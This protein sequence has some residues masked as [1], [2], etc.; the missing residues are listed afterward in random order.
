[1]VQPD[2]ALRA[3]DLA[4]LHQLHTACL[5]EHRQEV[6]GRLLVEVDLAVD[7]RRHGGLRIGDPHQFDAIDAGNLGAGEGGRRLGARHIVLV[8]EIDRL[9]ARNPLILGKHVGTGSHGFLH[10]LLRIGERILLAH[11][12]G[13]RALALAQRLQHHAVGFAQDHGEGLVVDRLHLGDEAH[14]TLADAILGAPALQRGDHVLGRDRRSV[15]ELEPIA[16]GEGIGEPV[17]ADLVLAHHLGLRLLVAVVAEQRVVDQCAMDVGD[18]L[19]GPHWIDDAH[20][21]MHHRLEY[22]FLRLHVGGGKRHGQRKRAG[23]NTP[24]HTKVSLTPLSEYAKPPSSLSSATHGVEI[25]RSA[26]AALH[27]DRAARSG[28]RPSGK[29]PY[30]D[31]VE[32][33]RSIRHRSPSWRS[34]RRPP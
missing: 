34:G 17:R 5:F 1:M 11:D 29:G 22:L 28:A 4:G 10:L 8:L 6:V 18:R 23:E 12:G 2:H 25:R 20:I 14:Q 3:V 15:V 9:A 32:A 31:R 21:G 24:E 19:G 13:D 33:G 7:Q 16:Q 26:R 27:R 30:D